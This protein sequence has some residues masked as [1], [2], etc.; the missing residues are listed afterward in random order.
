M[1]EEVKRQIVH[2]TI[3]LGA[4][5]FLFLFGR[6]IF[7]GAVF[8]TILFGL[9]L[10]NRL[11]LGTKLPFIDWFIKNFERKDVQFPGWGSA[12]YATGVLLVSCFVTNINFI[13]ASLII[14]ALGDGI[15]TIAGKAGRM[16][17]PYNKK[18][19]LEGSVAF[20]LSSLAGYLFIGPLIIPA[21]VVAMIVESLPIPMDDNLTL[22]IALIIFFMVV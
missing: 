10:I 18:K 11:Y 12:C 13:A 19:K 17:I 3:G 6:G 8:F 7:I 4:L 16:S 1:N 21:A 22:P 5:A 14:I 9:I 2:I 15:A 20:F